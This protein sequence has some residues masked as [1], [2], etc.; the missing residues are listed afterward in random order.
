MGLFDKFKKGGNGPTKEEKKLAK[1]AKNSDDN[2]EACDAARKI[3]NLSLL[4]DL[5]HINPEKG[6]YNENWDVRAIAVNNINNEKTLTKILLTHPNDVVRYIAL[7]KLIEMGVED[8]PTLIKVAKSDDSENVRREAIERI[9]DK[10]VLSEIAKNDSDSGN[11]INALFKLDDVDILTDIA[12]KDEDDFVR[13]RASERLSE[14]NSELDLLVSPEDV[15][16]IDDKDKIIDFA[17]NAVNPDSR[18][19][20]IEKISNENILADIAKTDKDKTVR[21]F[22]REKISDE[23]LL[24]EIDKVN[25]DR[26]LDYFHNHK[27]YNYLNEPNK[28]SIEK[29]INEYSFTEE[30]TIDQGISLLI[31]QQE[32]ENK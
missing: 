20:A 15:K 4:V 7:E 23:T 16:N 3:T 6:I 30:D 13:Q 21:S 26:L 11:R 25:A 14:I 1:I 31:T 8:E 12:Q 27:Y 22:A 32:L 19:I 9:E 29:R 5:T 24:A 17:K 28:N 2:H 10:S 18:K